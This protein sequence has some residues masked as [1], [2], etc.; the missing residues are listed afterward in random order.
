MNLNNNIVTIALLLVVV[1]IIWFFGPRLESY[2]GTGDYSTLPVPIPGEGSTTVGPSSGEGPL[3]S[4][5]N[6][7]IGSPD[8][9]PGDGEKE[10]LTRRYKQVPVYLPSPN[11]FR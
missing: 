10:V 4:V 1:G 5:Y 3:S 11:F 9:F 8:Y 7:V 6:P 2:K